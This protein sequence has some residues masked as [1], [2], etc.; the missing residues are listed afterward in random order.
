MLEAEV[1]HYREW[2]QSIKVLKLS[3]YVYDAH[4]TA[5]TERLIRQLWSGEFK[6]ALTSLPL[7][8]PEITSVLLS[9]TESNYVP[10]TETQIN[11]HSRHRENQF[12]GLFTVLSRMRSINNIPLLTVLLSLRAYRVKASSRFKDALAC[13]F[14]GVLL[15][16]EWVERLVA[17][18][19]EMDPG[20][21]YEVLQG[22]GACIFDN[23]TI[24]VAYKSYSTQDSTGYRL[25]MTNWVKMPLP[26]QLLPNSTDAAT[27]CKLLPPY[28]SDACF[29]ITHI[30]RSA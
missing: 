4:S 18:A 8:N 2:L 5:D 23:L 22:I 12:E 25:D 27:I 14:R 24:R 28:C 21:P 6:Q 20:P 1:A 19:L 26:K 9:L 3:P 30:T 10:R 7:A 16:D 15:S 13:F 17:R 11:S 29:C